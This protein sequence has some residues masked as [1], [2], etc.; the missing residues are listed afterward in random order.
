M[1]GE[2]Y[3][4]PAP[5]MLPHQPNGATPKE[6]DDRP[7]SEPQ[8]PTLGSTFYNSLSRSISSLKNSQ[9]GQTITRALSSVGSSFKDQHKGKT[10]K[11]APAFESIP[12][13]VGMLL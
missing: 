4:G 2:G 5:G 7:R 10:M 12:V 1:S 13:I 9:A 3:A 8:A 6:H 11:V